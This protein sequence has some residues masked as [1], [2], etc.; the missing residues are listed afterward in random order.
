[1]NAVLAR[2]L[3]A[4][5]YPALA[6]AYFGVPGLPQNLSA[7]LLEYFERALGWLAAQPGVDPARLVVLGGSRGSEA[8]ELLAVHDPDRCA[9]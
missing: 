4:H 5:G 8:A 2:M 1:M 7:I 3:A 6:V 9:P